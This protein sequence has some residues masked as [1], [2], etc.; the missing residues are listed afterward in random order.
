MQRAI[1]N[2]T[3]NKTITVLL[4]M[5]LISLCLLAFSGCAQTLTIGS[6]SDGAVKIDAKN[7]TGQA[8][9]ALAVKNSFAQDFTDA[10]EQQGDWA[11]DA[12]ATLYIDP[13]IIE[14]SSEE[15]VEGQNGTATKESDVMIAPR[16]DIQITTADG[17]TYELHQLNASDIK[18]AT[19]KIENGTAYL[20]YTSIA[21]GQ[22]VNTL[23]AELAYQEQ[24]RAAA[25]AEAAAQQAKADAEKAANDASADNK[26]QSSSSSKSSG[27]SGSSSSGSSTG[28]SKAS[29]SSSGSSSSGSTG[30]GSASDGEDVCVDDIILN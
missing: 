28:S 8:I 26:K 30:S 15:T 16:M 11:N 22:E 12:P 17:M 21:S 7:E 29:G 14:V 2:R 5:T 10:L 27:T 24:A 1:K 25:E 20:V 18:D 23:E 6:N 19:L 13:A 3:V 4:T 9:T